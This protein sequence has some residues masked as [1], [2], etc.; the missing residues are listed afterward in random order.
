VG[1]DELELQEGGRSDWIV[2]GLDLLSQ[3]RGRDPVVDRALE[4][5]R[6]SALPVVRSDGP[7]R[8]I[9]QDLSPEH[10]LV[11]P[12]TGRLTGI[13]DWTDAIIGDAARDFVFLVAWRGWDFAEEVMRAYPHPLDPGFRDRLRFMTRVLTV[14]WLGYSYERRTEVEKLTGW[15]HN[16]YAPSTGTGNRESGIGIGY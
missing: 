13:L 9:H 11:D 14:V 8:F 12:S 3:R 1:V 15:V 5:A 10:L 6:H 16:A 7:L 4:W 2:T